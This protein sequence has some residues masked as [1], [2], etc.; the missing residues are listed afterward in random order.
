MITTVSSAS[1]TIYLAYLQAYEDNP[2]LKISLE[3]LIINGEKV[4]HYFERM[5]Q[6]YLDTKD[7]LIKSQTFGMLN[8]QDPQ[9]IEQFAISHELGSEVI[10]E[11]MFLKNVK[12]V[13][14]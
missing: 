7:N 10:F 1:I 6:R 14:L 4:T 8:R 11:V 5:H 9:D 3:D 2:M 13:I 12:S